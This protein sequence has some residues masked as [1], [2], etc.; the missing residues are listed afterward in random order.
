MTK[1]KLPPITADQREISRLRQS[2]M[3]IG[4]WARTFDPKFETAEKAMS[5]IIRETERV[6]GAK[7]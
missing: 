3:S 5:D 2:L 6:L 1:T 7:K 4:V